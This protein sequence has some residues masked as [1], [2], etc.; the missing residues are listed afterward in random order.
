M[1]SIDFE[2]PCAGFRPSSGMFGT[3]RRR[4][5]PAQPQQYLVITLGVSS[6][7]ILRRS[8]T[9][10]DGKISILENPFRVI[11]ESG[12]DF[13]LQKVHVMNLSP[14]S[15]LLLGN[16]PHTFERV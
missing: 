7:V 6:A 3:P 12:V 1:L 2:L 8:R 11:A 4:S 13:P 14:I 5:A 9:L 15:I 10:S 16:S